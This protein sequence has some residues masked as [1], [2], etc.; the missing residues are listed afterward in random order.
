LGRRKK[1]LEACV[2]EDKGGIHLV[3]SATSSPRRGILSSSFPQDHRKTVR[4]EWPGEGRFCLEVKRILCG[5]GEVPIGDIN[6]QSR[7]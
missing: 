5:A 7:T 6:H 2:K 4:R 3:H 1:A